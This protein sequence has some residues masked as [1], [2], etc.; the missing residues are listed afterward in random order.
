MKKKEKI[1]SLKKEI[2]NLK[3]EISLLEKENENLKSLIIPEIKNPTIWPPSSNPWWW[4]T[5][6]EFTTELEKT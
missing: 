5:K 2:K 1:K 4:E 6:I 3:K